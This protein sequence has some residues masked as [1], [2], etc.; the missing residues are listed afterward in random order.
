ML[1]GWPSFFLPSIAIQY[2]L[3]S[4][5]K[6]NKNQFVGKLVFVKL[7]LLREKLFYRGLKC[8]SGAEFWRNRGG[9]LNF[10]AGARIYSHTARSFFSHKNAK[11]GNCHFFF[12]EIG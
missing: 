11:T 5:L 8:F 9:N 7:I 2:T 3:G 1:L 4:Y 6:V 10:L 12:F